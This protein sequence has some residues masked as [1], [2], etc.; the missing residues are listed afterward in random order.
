MQDMQP[1]PNFASDNWAPAHPEVMDA[2]VRANHDAAPAYGND[3]YTL[4]A[5]SLIREHFGAAAQPFFVFTGTGANVLSLESCIRAYETV[6]CSDCAHIYTS[7]WGAPE[8]MTGSKLSPIHTP[9]GK[10]S[11]AGIA[12][13]IPHQDGHAGGRPGVVSLTQATEY[14]TVYTPDEISAIVHVA[15]ENGLYV[16]MDGARLGNAAASLGVSMSGASTDS[17]VDVLSFGGTKNG[18]F[19]AEAIVFM[20][21]HLAR[22]FALRRKQAMQLASKMRFMS[23]Q[24]TALLTNELWLR[25]ARH[26]NA[27]ARRLAEGLSAISGMRTTQ[28]VQAN[29]VF[30]AVPEQ[31]IAALQGAASLQVWNVATSELRLVCSFQTTDAEVDNFV[32]HARK[33]VAG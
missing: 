13:A 4:E 9:D 18:A 11:A 23:V 27:M 16:H 28:P 32:A 2:V 17:G 8:R 5:E 14:G 21:E 20:N 19:C 1:L 3:P 31:A 33:V 30:V 25:N 29:E 10:L 24:F 6:I 26:A 12:A 15:H 22:D 7:E